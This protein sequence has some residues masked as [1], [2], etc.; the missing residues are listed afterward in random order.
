MN[1]RMDESINESMNESMNQL[2]NEGMTKQMNECPH[3]GLT[4]HFEFI[5]K[6]NTDQFRSSYP[7]NLWKLLSD[8]LKEIV[9]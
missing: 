9:F 3:T 2:I 7:R 6:K 4:S 5:L 8:F 1:E